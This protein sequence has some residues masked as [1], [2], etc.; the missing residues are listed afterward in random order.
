MGKKNI[1][2]KNL[3]EKDKKTILLNSNICTESHG[4]GCND[5]S[6]IEKN[7]KLN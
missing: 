4:K 1:A 5:L 2:F 3:T 6:N 7:K